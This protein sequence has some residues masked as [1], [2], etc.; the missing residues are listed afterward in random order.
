VKRPWIATQL[1]IGKAERHAYTVEEMKNAIRAA[2]EIAGIDALMIMPATDFALTQVLAGTSRECGIKT[3]LW[4][5]VL[6]DV[7]GLTADRSGLVQSY[8]QDS[9]GRKTGAWEGL[10]NAKDEFQFICPNNGRSLDRV[11]GIYASLLDR[12]PL[13][14]VMLD[15]VRFPSPANGF[16]SLLSC[17]CGSCKTAFECGDGLPFET[18]RERARSFVLRIKDPTFSAFAAEWRETDSLWTVAGLEQLAAFRQRSVVNAV[19]RFC[20]HARSKGLK[21]GLDLFSYSLSHLVGQDYAALSE[22]C[23][24]VKPMIYCHAVGPAGLPLE[25]ACMGRAL[26]ELSPRLC[27]GEVN[28]LLRKLFGWDIP[29]TEERLLTDGLPEKILSSELALITQAGM[30][31]GVDVYAGIEAVRNPSFGIDITVET[32]NRY[33]SY[34]VEPA[35][36]IVASWNLLDIPR[37]NLE[38]IGRLG[39]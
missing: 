7:P 12:L 31:S 25:I 38:R 18:L 22:N 35:R 32:M 20:A 30:A 5:P 29:E 9:G 1:Y 8:D 13:D 36:G 3:Y 6:A 24:W 23:D 34:L 11:F 33:F 16:E 26:R 2:R 37:E 15:R 17:F 21:V 27:A 28:E 4:F 39:N 10:E 19:R 14:G